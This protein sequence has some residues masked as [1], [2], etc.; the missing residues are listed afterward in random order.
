ML[1]PFTIHQPATVAEA[2][3]LLAHHGPDSAIYAGGTELLIVMKER[4]AHFP[5]LIDIKRIPGLRAIVFDDGNRQLSIGALASH[6]DIERSPIIRERIPELASL[7][8]TVANVRVRNAGTIG[9]N[10]C[11]ADPH[12]D[13]ATLFTALGATFSLTSATGSRDVAAED[14]ITGFMET[15]RR[16]DEI[17]TAISLLEPTANVGIAYERIKLHE[18]PTAAVAAVIAVEDGRIR[19]ARVVAGSVGDRPQRLLMVEAALA[20]A[21]ASAET[22][23][24]TGSILRDDVQTETD[25]FESEPYKRQLVRTAGM[26]AIA[27]AIDSAIGESGGRRAA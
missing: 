5:H 4:L 26:K 17:L 21:L 12:S 10:L 22:T 9:G 3:E 1:D 14:F 25:A 24:V 13:P 7:A 8:S 16:H 6:R 18:R 19:Q 2:S 11:F 15:V 27:R 23:L 20:G